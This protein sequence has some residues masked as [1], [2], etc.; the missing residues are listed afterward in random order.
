M[1]V[2]RREWRN[3]TVAWRHGD[4]FVDASHLAA[5]FQRRPE[6]YLGLSCTIEY[7]GALSSELDMPVESTDGAA[8]L[9]DLSGA[10]W[11]FHPRVAIDFARWLSPIFA[12]WMDRQY[13]DSLAPSEPRS[14]RILEDARP[15]VRYREQIF[16]LNETDL[17]TRVVKYARKFHPRAI[18]CA[19]LGELQ[20][21]EERRLSAW[22]KG[23][24]RGQP[25][26]LVLNRHR[27][28]TGLAIEF[29]HPGFEPVA[30]PAQEEWFR[31]LQRQGWLT[32]LSNDYDSA[33][34]CID[35]YARGFVDDE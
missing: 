10:V 11:W 15:A 9:T 23:Y 14:L 22:A 30:T 1:E 18:L 32:L 16:I 35:E 26:L 27:R 8:S 20:D 3:V 28:W 7:L 33:C 4:N 6:S 17:H 13:I 24:L 21:T 5:Q 29:K 25:D 19:G 12:V 31:K 34:R 2:V